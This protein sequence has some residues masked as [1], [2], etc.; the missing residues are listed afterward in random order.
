MAIRD[1]QHYVAVETWAKGNAGM[2]VRDTTF[3]LAEPMPNTGANALVHART[4]DKTMF[5]PVVYFI[6]AGYATL[7]MPDCE[8]SRAFDENAL[9][10]VTKAFTESEDND[11]TARQD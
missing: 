1:L 7:L 2:E 9:A 10:R 3:F 5:I 4:L 11:P 8:I 6:A